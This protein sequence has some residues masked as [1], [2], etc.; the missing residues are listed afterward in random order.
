VTYN[1]HH[2]NTVNTIYMST[3]A[4]RCVRRLLTNYTVDAIHTGDIKIPILI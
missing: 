2:D 3:A 4:I 1:L